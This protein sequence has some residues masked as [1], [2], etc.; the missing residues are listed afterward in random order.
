MLCFSHKKKSFDTL[1]I[2]YF[3]F[4]SYYYYFLKTCFSNLKFVKERYIW[5]V[6]YK[7][8]ELYGSSS[9]FFEKLS[10]TFYDYTY[11]Q[12]TASIACNPFFLRFNFSAKVIIIL[13]L[14]MWGFIMWNV[15]NWIA[16]C[17][18]YVRRFYMDE[19]FKRKKCAGN[20]I[21]ISTLLRYT[22]EFKSFFL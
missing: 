7:I 4:I 14:R 8:E 15:F 17:W 16:S 12:L 1:W 13:K 19:G 6:F 3:G 18:G 20:I 9:N 22:T 10:T 5:M 2:K 11:Y 21:R